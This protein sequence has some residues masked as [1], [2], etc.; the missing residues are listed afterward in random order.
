M[1]AAIAA[2][3]LGDNAI[4]AAVAGKKIRV[5]DIVLSAL[6]ANNVKARSGAT[7]LTGL[8]YLPA[9][10]TVPVIAAKDRYLFETAAGAALNLNLSAATAVGGWVSYTL[11]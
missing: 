10:S 1:L 2:S 9:T 11:E 5:Q 6:T 3:A 8:I 7:D 4:V